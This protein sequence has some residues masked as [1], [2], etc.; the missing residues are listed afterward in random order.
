MS[1]QS[2]VRRLGRRFRAILR[3]IGK[4]PDHLATLTQRSGRE[5]GFAD[6][7]I[8]HLEASARAT[9]LESGLNASERA[10]RNMADKRTDG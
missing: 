8:Q 6:S 7:A 9:C 4:V 10:E 1:A 2:M 5:L 3:P